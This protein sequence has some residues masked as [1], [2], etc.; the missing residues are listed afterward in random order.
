MPNA[1]SRMAARKP[2]AWR[3]PVSGADHSGGVMP[4]SIVDLTLRASYRFQDA[5]PR[6]VRARRRHRS[7]PVRDALVRARNAA[8]HRQGQRTP[9]VAPGR[10]AD[11][12]EA[13]DAALAGQ[14]G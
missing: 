13:D 3:R 4:P 8:Q 7:D 9:E 12:G 5:A 10:P 14:L 1:N 11:P 2:I 6:G